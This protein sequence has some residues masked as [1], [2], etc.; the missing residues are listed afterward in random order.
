M[1]LHLY[2]AIYLLMFE[3]IM[4]LECLP[5]CVLEMRRFVVVFFGYCF[6]CYS[7]SSHFLSIWT[8]FGDDGPLFENRFLFRYFVV[9]VWLLL[10]MPLLMLRQERGLCAKYCFIRIFLEQFNITNIHSIMP[11]ITAQQ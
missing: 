5:Q 9:V 7:V 10:L 8:Q 4:Y 11:P 1:Y 6:L 3:Y 2:L